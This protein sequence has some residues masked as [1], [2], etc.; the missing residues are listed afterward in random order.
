MVKNNVKAVSFRLKAEIGWALED[1][2]QKWGCSQTAALE[3]C[4]Q[5]AAGNSVSAILPGNSI[6]RERESEA[7]AGFDP[8]KIPGVRTGAAVGGFPCTCKHTGCQGR[9]FTGRTRWA[10][11]CDGCDEKGHKG[12]PRECVECYNDRG[13]A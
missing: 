7:V 3:R 12:E 5:Q 10:T 2:A 4:I 6:I 1:L 9:K 13:P 8:S 11:M